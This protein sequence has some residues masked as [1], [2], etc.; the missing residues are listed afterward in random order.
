MTGAYDIVLFL[1]S[2]LRWLVLVLLVGTVLN[3]LGGWLGRR[4]WAPRDNALSGTLVG[5]ADLQFLLGLAL[6]LGLSPHYNL[7]DGVDMKVRHD[8]FFSVEH[9]SL[10]FLAIGALHIGRVRAKKAGSAPDKH[11]A[12]AVA[13]LIA[14]VLIAAS[15]PWPFRDL[16]VARPLFRTGF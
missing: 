14:A 12:I 3:A 15:I 13:C 7:L 5:L 6:V 10:M 4:G 1:H 2:N 16:E 11:R 8:R 9:F